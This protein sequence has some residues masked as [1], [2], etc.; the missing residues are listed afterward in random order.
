MQPQLCDDFSSVTETASEKTNS[1]LPTFIGQSVFDPDVEG[2]QF[3][4]IYVSGG[5]QVLSSEIVDDRRS[6]NDLLPSD[7]RPIFARLRIQN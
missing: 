6:D 2:C 4:H 5:I 1:Q 7:H 3:D